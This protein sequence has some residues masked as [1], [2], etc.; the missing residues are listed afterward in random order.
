MQNLHRHV[1]YL[2][3]LNGFPGIAVERFN[4]KF[5]D[6]GYSGLWDIVR[7]NRQTNAGEN[8]TCATAVRR[9][10]DDVTGAESMNT[11]TIIIIIINI[12]S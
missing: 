7:I 6:A 2:V 9:G 8:R 11:F 1:L 10:K 3:T 12:R 4:V 5:G